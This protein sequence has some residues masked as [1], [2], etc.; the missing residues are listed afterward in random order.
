MHAVV[1]K[2]C[3]CARALRPQ[4][5]WLKRGKESPAH[6]RGIAVRRAVTGRS[7]FLL[8]R[9]VGSLAV[10]PH[11][12]LPSGLLPQTS[13]DHPGRRCRLGLSGESPGGLIRN[14]GQS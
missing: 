8:R 1:E 2:K 4:E 12:G 10:Q 7:H 3:V 11:V 5:R 14:R 9:M 6:Q 13:I